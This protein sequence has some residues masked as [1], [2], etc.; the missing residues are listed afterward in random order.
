MVSSHLV[1]RVRNC[2]LLTIGAKKEKGTD[3]A[4]YA[5][6]RPDQ[7][8]KSPEGKFSLY[9]TDLNKRNYGKILLK[10]RQKVMDICKNE[11]WN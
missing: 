3:L 2:D 6:H 11:V 1:V 7:M 4:K 8:R 5:D 10:R 9:S